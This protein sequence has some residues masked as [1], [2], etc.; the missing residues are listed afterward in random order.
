TTG[1]ELPDGPSVGA[2]EPGSAADR[3]GLKPGDVILKVDGRDVD[4]EVGL[5]AALSPAEWPRGKNDL[6]LTVA[7][8]K[9]TLDLTFAPKTLGLH[10]TQLYE[11]ISTALL[12]FLLLAYYPFRRHDGE[13]FALF[14]MLYPL[15]RFLDEML[16]ADNEPVALGMTLSQTGSL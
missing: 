1:P 11:S 9:E 14:L 8:G 16:R 10:P 4:S 2:V 5:W 6:T 15:H 12:L 13:L 7:R 3:A